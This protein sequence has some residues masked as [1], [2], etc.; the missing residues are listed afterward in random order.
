MTYKEKQGQSVCC[1]LL[2]P[3]PLQC[4]CARSL[5]HTAIENMSKKPEDGKD[6]GK[7]DDKSRSS[8][9]RV[10][11]PPLVPLAALVLTIVAD[12]FR[13][14]SSRSSGSSSR[15]RSSRSDRDRDGKSDGKS[16]TSSR[17]D[18]DKDK[19]GHRS[20]RHRS[21]RE[22]DKSGSSS[23]DKSDKDKSDKKGE[24]RAAVLLRLGPLLCLHVRV[25]RHTGQAEARC[26]RHSLVRSRPV[27]W[28]ALLRPA[29][30]CNSI[31][32]C[33]L[34]VA[35]LLLA[36][37]P[38]R[39]SLRPLLPAVTARAAAAAARVRLP[40][41]RANAICTRTAPSAW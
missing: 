29:L 39:A 40:S 41:R 37:V 22:K 25:C 11:L 33:S 30:L 17:S 19:D 24:V 32:C 10:S 26:G 12:A 36:G 13:T 3:F 8:K 20:S 21:D 6:S 23:K 18:K 7:K 15:H 28:C 27:R 5:A 16:S 9:D 14:Q 34:S 31:M 38:A 35:Q 1:S 2:L 4:S